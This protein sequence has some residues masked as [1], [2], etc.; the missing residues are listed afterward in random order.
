MQEGGRIYAC[1]RKLHEA[2]QDSKRQH[3][4]AIDSTGQQETV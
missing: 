4:T 3:R 1:G 2:V